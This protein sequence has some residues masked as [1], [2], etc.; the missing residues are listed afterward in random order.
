MS[1]GSKIN[2]YNAYKHDVTCLNAKQ[3]INVYKVNICS[4]TGYSVNK[5]FTHTLYANFVYEF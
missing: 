3:G 1:M 5:S 2:V 4:K